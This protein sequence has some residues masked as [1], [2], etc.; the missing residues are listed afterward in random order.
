MGNGNYNEREAWLV[1]TSVMK[2][3]SRVK[4]L[5]KNYRDYLFINLRKS[6]A[7]H[8]SDTEIKSIEK[9]I[10]ELAKN[11]QKSVM[12]NAMK[13]LGKGDIK[14]AIKQIGSIFG[15]DDAKEVQKMIDEE[16]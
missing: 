6:Y 2:T 5:P 8:L 15:R 13:M 3:S 7:P 4:L 1:I 14:Q 16:S 11:I 9:Y 10:D 12:K